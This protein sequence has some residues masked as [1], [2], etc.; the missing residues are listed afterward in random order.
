MRIPFIRLSHLSQSNVHSIKRAYR[1]SKIITSNVIRG[2]PVK[3]E[4]EKKEKRGRRKKGKNCSISPTPSTT[5]R[6]KRNTISM[7]YEEIFLFSYF[8]KG[9]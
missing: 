6:G 8:A 7:K 3:E 5:T 1:L 4:K 9:R 2:L